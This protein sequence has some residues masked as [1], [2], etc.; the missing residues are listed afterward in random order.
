MRMKRDRWEF[1]DWASKGSSLIEESS[2]H[3][4]IRIFYDYVIYASPTDKSVTPCLTGEGWENWV[5]CWVEN[6]LTPETLFIDIGANCGYYSVLAASQGS[7]VWAFE[8]NPQYFDLLNMTASENRFDMK[9]FH[10]AL[11]DESGEATLHIPDGLEGSASLREVPGDYSIKEVKVET[12]KLDAYSSV[13]ITSPILIKMDVESNE[14]N[15]WNGSEEFRDKF[16]PTFVMEYTPGKYSD[17]FVESM[18][19]YGRLSY[20]DFSGEEHPVSRETLEAS[21]DWMT[22]VVRP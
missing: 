11:S 14:E 17:K 3:S 15:V 5:S 18:E 9:V 10:F 12:V 22:V 1:E 7:E 16:S 20:I 13:N 2:E 6:E 21:S 19:R 8:P 4:K